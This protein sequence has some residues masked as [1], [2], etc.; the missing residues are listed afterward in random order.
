MYINDFMSVTEFLLG[1]S[2]MVWLAWR[3]RRRGL[4][5]YKTGTA[6]AL[7]WCDPGIAGH[8]G[9]WRYGLEHGDMDWSMVIWTPEENNLSG[10][11]LSGFT[12]KLL[13]NVVCYFGNI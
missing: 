7:L 2:G 9:A 3:M 11:Q 12:S 6:G 13:P 8:A 5:T 1:C 4:R 10:F